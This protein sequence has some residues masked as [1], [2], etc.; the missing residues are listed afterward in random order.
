MFLSESPSGVKTAT[1]SSPKICESFV[2]DTTSWRGDVNGSFSIGMG[3]DFHQH[4]Q[5]TVLIGLGS[6]AAFQAAKICPVLMIFGTTLRQGRLCAG[7]MKNGTLW[8]SS[9]FLSA[10]MG[11][12]GLEETM[13]YIHL[14]PERLKAS[15]GINWDMLGDIYKTESA[16]YEEN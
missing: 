12:A 4:G 10:Y 7:W 13:Y 8:H 9:L 1:L 15:P 16:F 3:V 5:E 14:L 11:H 2:P 6:E